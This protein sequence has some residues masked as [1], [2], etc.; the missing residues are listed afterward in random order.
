MRHAAMHAALGFFIYG[1]S[2]VP[3]KLLV[4]ED[5]EIEREGLVTVL[6]RD[7]F[8]VI[9]AAD[10][11]TGMDLAERE[12]PDLILLDMMM[13]GNDGW[14]FLERR[15]EGML[16]KTPVIIVTG[17]VIAHDEWAIGLGADELVKKPV[18][19]GELVQKIHQMIA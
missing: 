12:S 10:A 11:E 5:N 13:G 15:R 8:E 4:V 1:G 16:P 17:L 9:A 2:I 7:G 18:D 19:H 3:A 14:D 6:R